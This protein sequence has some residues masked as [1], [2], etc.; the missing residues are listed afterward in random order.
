MFPYETY[1]CFCD[2]LKNNIGEIAYVGV[3]YFTSY[4]CDDSTF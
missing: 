1:L 4:T 2:V 3:L